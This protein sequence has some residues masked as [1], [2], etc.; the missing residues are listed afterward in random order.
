MEPNAAAHSSSTTALFDRISAWI[1]STETDK[2]PPAEFEAEIPISPTIKQEYSR[3]RAFSDI[4]DAGDGRLTEQ[5][6]KHIRTI[7]PAPRSALGFIADFEDAGPSDSVSQID[8]DVSVHSATD[9]RN[10]SI[11]SSITSPG[12]DSPTKVSLSSGIT[13][14]VATTS[15]KSKRRLLETSTPNFRFL[16][17]SGRAGLTAWDDINDWVPMSIRK[18]AQGFSRS[19]SPRGMICSCVK[20]IIINYDPMLLWDDIT[21]SDMSDSKDHERHLREAEF[22]LEW[23]QISNDMHVHAAEESDWVRHSKYVLS[24]VITVNGDI[25]PLHTVGVQSVDLVREF[26]PRTRRR[27]QS[28]PTS[29][30]KNQEGRLGTV[31]SINPPSR[32]TEGVITARADL[33]VLLRDC[34]R[35]SSLFQ[36]LDD[37][38]GLEAYIPPFENFVEPPV[39]ML[40]VKSLDGSCLEAEN[41]TAICANAIL[42]SW[43]CLGKISAY[44][45]APLPRYLDAPT[46]SAQN[47]G[48]MTNPLEY[49][50]VEQQIPTDPNNPSASG[51]TSI[52]IGVDHVIAVQVASYSWSYTIVFATPSS[53]DDAKVQARRG[54]SRRVFGPHPIGDSRT[55]EGAYRI[56]R[57]L[58]QLFVYKTR[59]WLPGIIQ[60]DP[61]PMLDEFSV[62]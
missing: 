35:T 22:I 36:A 11:E 2:D 55:V 4:S 27:A 1:A 26:C 39:F 10:L 5:K 16:G 24:S 29:P 28:Q 47:L 12:D 20:D 9:I 18:L 53:E 44:N 42:E 8:A 49:P 59:V 34:G 40:D 62:S 45:S 61:M 48:P 19:T 57:F 32:V 50:T 52:Q 21:F 43:R 30:C 46:G 25:Y 33:T 15:P 6:R 38:F 37:K 31:T 3:K 54:Y 17:V 58:H 51:T 23:V 7:H 14:S 41:Q 60:R 56:C 13:P